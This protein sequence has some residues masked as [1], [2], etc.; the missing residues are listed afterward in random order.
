MNELQKNGNR[1][2]SCAGVFLAKDQNGNTFE[3]EVVWRPNGIPKQKGLFVLFPGKTSNDDQF[4][5]VTGTEYDFLAKIGDIRTDYF[6]A[7]G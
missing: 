2:P 3:L 5:P 6:E 7:Y 1:L 4:V